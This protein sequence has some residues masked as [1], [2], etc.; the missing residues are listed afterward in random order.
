MAEFVSEMLRMA[1]TAFSAGDTAK[2]E[3]VFTLDDDIDHLYRDVYESV[4]QAMVTQRHGVQKGMHLLFAAHNLERM[5][6]R[7]TN[8][9]E[10]IIFMRTGVMEEQNL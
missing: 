9:G 10:R 8:I 1:M 6:D 7:V 2:A 3:D 5:G 4:I